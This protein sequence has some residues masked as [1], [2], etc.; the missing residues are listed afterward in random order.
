MTPTQR[1]IAR[2]VATLIS[3][4][5]ERGESQQTVMF[6]VDRQFPNLTYKQF[7]SAVLIHEIRRAAFEGETVH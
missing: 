4:M 1:I 5:R 2:L 7:L 6:A 3:E